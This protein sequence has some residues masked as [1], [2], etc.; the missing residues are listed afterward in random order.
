MLHISAEEQKERLLARLDDPTKLLEVQ[1]RRHRRAAALAGVPARPTRSRSSAPTPSTRPWLVVPERPQVV[2]QPGRRAGAAARRCAAMDPTWPRPGLRRRRAAAPAATRSRRRD[3]VS[4]RDPH[5]HRDP[6]RRARCARAARC[7]ASSRP[8]TSAPT[9]A[10]SA[11]PARASR[12]WSPRWSS[13]SWPGALGIAHP[14]AGR[15]R[16]RRGDRPLRGRRGGAGPAH[17]EHRAA[18]SASTSCPARS[19]T[20]PAARPTRTV[21]GRGALARRAAPPTSTAAGATPTCW[22]GTATCGRSTTA[23]ACT[24]TTAGPAASGPPSGSRAQPYDA[25][26]H[27]LARA[28]RRA[29]PTPTPSSRPQVTARPARARC[30]PRCPTS[31]SSRCPVRRRR[32]TLR[33]AYV[34]FLLRPGRPATAAWLPGAAARHE[35][36]GMPFQYVVLRCVPRV[37]R[38]E[39]VNVGVVA[40]LPAGRVP[41]RPLPRRPRPAGR[42]RPGRR[43]R[44]GVLG[45]GRRRGGLPRRRRRPVRRAGPPWAPASASSRRRAA[46]SSSRARCTAAPPPTRPPSSTH[47]LRPAGPLGRGTLAASPVRG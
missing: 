26:D 47:L 38:E 34:D 4:R 29:C 10:S 44:R 33:A 9:S 31:G 6:L 17:R 43:R 1:P 27:V 12:C 2:P 16:A 46:P 42:A 22:S 11:A 14:R 7:P 21:A 8:T 23:P 45:A 5:R 3:G 28:P 13:A 36:A 19:G 30:S 40:L 20:T 18:T 37:D 15:G 41:R 35:H 39:F 25:S 24:S 32:T